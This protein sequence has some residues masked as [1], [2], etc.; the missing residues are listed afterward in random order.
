MRTLLAFSSFLALAALSPA[1]DFVVNGDFEAGNTGFTSDY[2]YVTPGPGHLGAQGVY[3]IDTNPH[4]SHTSFA[5]MG[6]HTTGT[7]LMMILNGKAGDSSV[8]EETVTGLLIGE[9]YTFS[10]W[11]SSVHPTSPASLELRVNGLTVDSI[12]LSSTTNY[13][14]QGLGT[15]TAD[16]T[17]ATLRIVDV[18]GASSGND[19]A[20]DDIS[21]AGPVPEPA[22]V[23]VFCVLSGALLRK[24]RR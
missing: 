5:N 18:N 6:D 12:A 23:A 22:T 10:A 9:L 19:F 2:V 8:W 7:G 20:V 1:F 21:F 14:L 15:W 11:A 3:T 17:T 4:N 24:R 16:S 13:W